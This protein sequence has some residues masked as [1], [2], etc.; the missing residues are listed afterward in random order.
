MSVNTAGRPDRRSW[1][2]R[3]LAG[4]L[5]LPTAEPPALAER[6]PVRAY[7]I[8]DG[9]PADQVTDMLGDSR[10]F[11]WLVTTQGLTRFDGHEFRTYGTDPGSGPRRLHSLLETRRGELWLATDVGICRF[12]PEGSERFSCRALGGGGPEGS[13]VLSLAESGDGRLWAGTARGLA[14]FDARAGGEATDGGEPGVP[15]R[16]VLAVLEDRRGTLWIGGKRWLDRRSPDGALA[17]V[18]L[19]AQGVDEIVGFL[20]DRT[21][22]IWAATHSGLCRIAL[23]P[24]D[25]REA[26][27]RIFTRGDG[28]PSEWLHDLL[29]TRDGALWVAT[30]SGLAQAI[31]GPDGEIR[32]FVGYGPAEGV[33]GEVLALA[34]DAAGNVWV[35]GETTGALRIAARGFTSYDERDGLAGSSIASIGESPGG[36]LVVV[37]G[38]VPV[39]Q[40]VH[41]FDGARFHRVSLPRPP[42]LPDG[43]GWGWNQVTF[44]DARGD[45]WCPTGH[46]VLRYDGA[47]RLVRW[48]RAR[49]GLGSED[50][51]RMFPD[52]RGDVWI[53]GWGPHPLTRWIR[54]E[55]RFERFGPEAGYAPDRVP[56]SFAEDRSGQLWIGFWGGGLARYRGGRFETFESRDGVP[57]GSIRALHVD[58]SGGLW[59]ASSRGGIARVAD[60][61]AAR[62]AFAPTTTEEGLSTNDCWCVTE[63]DHGR[64]YVG[65]AVGMD[66]LDPGSG[67]VKHLTTADGLAGS[68]VDT[69]FRDRRGTLWF[70]T[71]EG[72]SRLTPEADPSAPPRR[73]LITSVLVDGEPLP[74][75]SELGSSEIE[76]LVLG[77]QT[78]SLEIRYAS[79]HFGIGNPPRYEISLPDQ[80]A[81]PLVTTPQRSILLPRPPSGRHR[82]LVRAVNAEG[83][84]SEPA[85]VAFRVLPPI[86]RRRWFA[87]AVLAVVGG[88]VYGLS[89]LRWTRLLAIERV[90]TRI[91]T[92]LHDEIGSS[93]TQIA[94]QSEVLR[95]ELAGAG[96]D[97]VGRLER[98]GEVSRQLIDAMSDIVWA[99]DP[100]RDRLRDLVQRMRRFALDTLDARGIALRFD[101]PDDRLDLPLDAESR[102]QIYLVF[103]ESVVNAARHS[104]CTS[105]E[106]SL[107]ISGRRAELT[108]RDD[109]R[110]FDSDTAPV[111]TGLISLRSRAEAM[112]GS[113]AIVSEPGKGTRVEMTVPLSAGP[114]RKRSDGFRL[115]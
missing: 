71:L 46:G 85:R 7:T 88:A 19:T 41:V 101:A 58:R 47:G 93:L 75:V 40:R 73:P 95:R 24:R 90:R 9:L 78:R 94:L 26:C 104:E 65:T 1:R 23:D 4:L 15:S 56:M 96:P 31:R 17:R 80:E 54:V 44:Q 48:Y 3:L 60:P 32:G 33:P 35:G 49:D 103:K 29:E 14:R 5:F 55:D 51:F 37:V 16:E 45:W 81:A 76:G 68:R 70:G 11:L 25:G 97:A 52:S 99:I 64:I 98:I 63:D 105:V 111:G 57:R 42:S 91:A 10:G 30:A 92:D 107:R 72:L 36:G 34:E 77:P 2:R 79:P 39:E 50:V 83:L 84:V 115:M 110:G 43:G 27:S 82:F 62:P 8:E 106:V 87:A 114:R 38:R 100:R 109:G 74:G 66:R 22:A 112:G 69:C 59:I 61:S 89:R 20:E 86:W 18:D 28:L 12:E 113:L 13:P 67:R 21:G 6:L 53:G 102:R 108:V